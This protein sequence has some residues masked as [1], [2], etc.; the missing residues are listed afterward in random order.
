M[1]NHAVK[2][3]PTENW[4]SPLLLASVESGTEV[5]KVHAAHSFTITLESSNPFSFAPRKQSKTVQ[6]IGLLFYKAVF[7]CL[8]FRYILSD[9]FVYLGIVHLIDNFWS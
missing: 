8:A 6:G 1:V 3:Q 2:S 5:F 9:W 7:Y 4:Y